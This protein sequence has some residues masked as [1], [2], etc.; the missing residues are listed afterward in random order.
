[1][2]N[3]LTPVTYARRW[4]TVPSRRVTQVTLKEEDGPGT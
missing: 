3:F 1:V 4:R 2:A